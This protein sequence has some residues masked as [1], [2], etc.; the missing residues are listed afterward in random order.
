MAGANYHV[1][2]GQKNLTCITQN[3]H[4]K[5]VCNSNTCKPQ[6]NMTHNKLCEPQGNI[7]SPR[8]HTTW[9]KSFDIGSKVS[10]TFFYDA[11]LA[12]QTELKIRSL[13]SPVWNSY[14]VG[15]RTKRSTFTQL[16]DSINSINTKDNKPAVAWRDYSVGN[17]V[18]RTFLQ[19]IVVAINSNQ[20]V[21]VCQCNY[22]TCNCHY[23]TC[24]CNYCGCHCDYCTCHCNYT[25]TCNCNYSDKRLKENIEYF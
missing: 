3:Y 6:N 20:D 10:S 5:I 23:C 9:T 4:G 22:C 2:S 15:T 16:V 21:C 12:I 1:C 25:C 11:I 18:S 24:D 14:D 13:A 19:Q 7:I 17:R 8:P